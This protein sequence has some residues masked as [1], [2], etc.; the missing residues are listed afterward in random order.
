MVEM[1]NAMNT[2]QKKQNAERQQSADI[3][4]PSFGKIRM[5]AVAAATSVKRKAAKATEAK[6]DLPPLLR[7]D[8]F[9]D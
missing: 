1:R 3:P 9:F 7:K 5:P 6:K 8:Q 4:C 2:D